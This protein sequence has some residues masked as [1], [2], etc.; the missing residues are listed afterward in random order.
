MDTN[1]E[2]RRAI[3]DELEY[4]P[5]FDAADILVSVEDGVVTLAGF[6]TSYADKLEAEKAAKRVYGVRDVIVDMEVRVPIA[7]RRPDED[8]EKAAVAAL[9][10]NTLLPKERV[11]VMV[12]DGWIT[13]EGELAWEYQ[14]E[15]AARA[16]R[17][18]SGVHGVNNLIVVRPNM[19]EGIIH[20]SL[21][22]AFRRS[23]EFDANAIR[24][25]ATDGKV[26]LSGNVQSWT[27]RGEAE[28]V[29]W[30]AP[31]VVEVENRLQVVA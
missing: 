23:A 27:E 4:E 6:V 24:V 8:I 3:L 16:V 7:A 21:L 17:Y 13:L 18:L 5:S 1:K 31:G 29:A 15:A 11:N 12:E 10:W 14:R 20:D 25:Q 19:A 26:T 28:R 2:L 9:E 30:A 22:D